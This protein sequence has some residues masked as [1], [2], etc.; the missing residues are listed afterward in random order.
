VKLAVGLWFV[1]RECG[2]D[3][4]GSSHVR[5][6]RLFRTA[7]GKYC[8]YSEGKL[9]EISSCTFNDGAASGSRTCCVRHDM[10]ITD[11]EGSIRPVGYVVFVQPEKAG[12]VELEQTR[13]LSCFRNLVPRMNGPAS[14]G[15]RES[16]GIDPARSDWDPHP[17]SE[18]TEHDVVMFVT[19]VTI[20]L[21]G[22]KRYTCEKLVFA[23]GVVFEA[24]RVTGLLCADYFQVDVVSS[25]DLRAFMTHRFSAA[26]RACMGQDVQAGSLKQAPRSRHGQGRPEKRARPVTIQS[27]GRGARGRL[28]DR[29]AEVVEEH[30]AST[31]RWLHSEL[32]QLRHKI[33]RV[34][35]SRSSS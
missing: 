14:E 1:V 4:V 10:P 13:A 22:S 5:M 6:L 19:H 20:N 18:S 23:Y 28:L 24:Y 7:D 9:R 17:C 15:A 25:S 3:F 12:D 32:L 27:G 8:V 11:Y 26:A 21:V 29:L 34:T 16:I 33:E 2:V 35:K 30:D 31:N